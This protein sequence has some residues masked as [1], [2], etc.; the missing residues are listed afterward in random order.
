MRARSGGRDLLTEAESKEFLDIYGIPAVKTVI[1]TNEDSAA[2]TATQI[3]YPVVLKLH[4]ETITHKTDVGGV[5]LNLA[6]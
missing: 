1:A 6:G 2:L 5:H 3:G 4:S